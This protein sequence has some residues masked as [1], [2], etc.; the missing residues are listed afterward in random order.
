MRN[1]ELPHRE[2]VLLALEHQQTDR[3]P[4][5]MVCSGVNPPAEKELERFLRDIR[6]IGVNEYFEPILDI[7]TVEPRYI[8]PP[9]RPRTDYWGVVRKPV[10]YGEGVYDE[11]DY[12]PLRLAAGIDDVMRH[13]WPTTDWFDYS[14]LPEEITRIN[15]REPFAVIAYNTNIFET[16]WYTRGFE[17]SLM[18]LMLDPELF[19]CILEKVTEFYRAHNRKMLQAAD[20]GIDLMFTADDIGGQ[21]GLLMSLELWRH[22]IK[23]HH[24]AVNREI[25]EFGAKVIYHSDGAI[26]EAVEDLIDMGIDI[27]QALQ[28]DAH[29]MDPQLLKDRYGQRL[30]FQGGI[31][32]QKTLP[33]GTPEQVRQET[34]ER[35]R[36][37]GKNGGYILGPS[38]AIQAG[39]PPENIVTMF[40]TA[41]SARVQKSV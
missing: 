30:C 8:G 33:F 27:L 20:G 12:Y 28:F 5:A 6:G 19:D 16:A 7:K 35:I 26:M 22:H 29:G 31:S 11:I 24:A 25:H 15:A 3:V 34:L 14:N 10:S 36:I 40:D 4:I 39:T 38:H 17:Q 9:L 21:N 13:P 32:V 1:G 37:L 41:A 2:R 23:P 18:D